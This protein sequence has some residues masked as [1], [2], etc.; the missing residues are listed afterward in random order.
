MRKVMERHTHLVR[1]DVEPT[2][3]DHQNGLVALGGTWSA[4]SAGL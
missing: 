4:R 1:F 3:G 2:A